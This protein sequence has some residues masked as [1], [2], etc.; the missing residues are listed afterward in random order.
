ML[1]SVP[2]DVLFASSQKI[3]LGLNR[4]DYML[5]QREDGTSALKQIEINTFAA[6]FGGLSSRTPDVHRSRQTSR[7]L[8]ESRKVTLRRRKAWQKRSLLSWTDTS[9]R[10]QE[11]PRRAGRS[12]TTTLQLDWPGLWLKPGSSTDQRGGNQDPSRKWR[13][14]VIS[15]VHWKARAGEAKRPLW[16]KPSEVWM[17]PPALAV[18]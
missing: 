10:W 17:N 8:L 3:V 7:G 18:V 4:S 13:T 9:W 16:T 11:G 12:W 15:T 1:T 5:D 2:A 14:A 6:S